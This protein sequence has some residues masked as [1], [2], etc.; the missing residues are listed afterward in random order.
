MRRS[1]A[2]GF[3]TQPLPPSDGVVAVR[4]LADAV[5]PDAVTLD[6]LQDWDP[7]NYRMTDFEAKWPVEMT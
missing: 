3:G 5:V 2:T 4:H 1:G 6:Y 7:N